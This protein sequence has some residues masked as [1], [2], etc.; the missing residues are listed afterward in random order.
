M[1]PSFPYSNANYAYQSFHPPYTTNSAHYYA[2]MQT[3]TDMVTIFLVAGPPAQQVQFFLDKNIA[4]LPFSVDP[5]LGLG[6][7]AHHLLYD[8]HNKA[9]VKPTPTYL[10]RPHPAAQTAL[11]LALTIP[12]NIVGTANKHKTGTIE[13]NV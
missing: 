7:F 8:H 1:T 6:P 11:E 12:T 5:F 4:R 9:P 10:Y 3:W 13:I 2:T